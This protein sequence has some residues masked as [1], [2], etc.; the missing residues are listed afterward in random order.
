MIKNFILSLVCFCLALTCKAGATDLSQFPNAVYVENL[1]TTAGSAITLSVKM[2]N[3]VPMTGF[4]FDIELPDGVSIPTDADGF[5]LINLSTDRTTAQKTNYFDNALQS[6]GSLRIMASSTRNY[7]FS[8]ND[9]EVA[10]ITINV[11]ETVTAG[12]YSIVL[13][14]IVLSDAGSK[15]YEVDRVEAELE[16]RGDA[17]EEIVVG[18]M[19]ND[20]ELTIEDVTL[21]TDTLLGKRPKQTFPAIHK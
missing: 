2:K 20:G 3:A 4:Q 12:R 13:K 21:L 1:S 11:A 5:Y 18:D 16:I 19:N 14:S 9:G 17:P 15:T 10:T 6:D 7:T 8:G